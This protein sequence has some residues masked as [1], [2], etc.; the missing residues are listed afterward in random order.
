M[1]DI[2]SGPGRHLVPPVMAAVDGSPSSYSAVAWA[3]VEASMHRCG[4]HLVNSWVLPVGFGPEATLSEYDLQVLQDEADHRLAEATQSALAAVGEAELTVTTE[5]VD[6]LIVPA[7]VA[8]SRTARMIVVGSRGLGALPRG[9]LGSVSTAVARHARCPVAVIHADASLDGPT[10]EEPV[11][12]GVDGSAHSV[13]AVRLAFDEAA[14]RQVGLIALHAWSDTSG[15]AIPRQKWDGAQDSARALLA[16]NLA[17]Y[18]ERYP[19]VAVERIVTADRPVR[20]LL[21][22]SVDAQL[23][24]VGSRGRGGFSTMLLGST[25]N[26]LLHAVDIPIIIARTGEGA[27]ASRAVGG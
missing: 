2:V 3:A 7:L 27:A 20:S 5:A 4:L 19:D 1:T 17:G 14:R 10:A 26:A 13:P 8:R 12:V 21:D 24:I 23:I 15:S 22:T 6:E 25:S 16:E 18:A 11:L 9:L